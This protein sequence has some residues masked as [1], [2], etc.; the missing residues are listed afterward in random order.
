MWR[1]VFLG[2]GIF[3]M[4][5]GLQFL[6]VDKAILRSREEPPPTLGIF[7]TS[8]ALGPNRTLTVQP[9]MPFSFMALGAVICIYCFTLPKR[10]N[11]G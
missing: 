4:I 9:W 7:E 1:A 6:A 2:L 5:L 8:P 3:L 10:I 11:G